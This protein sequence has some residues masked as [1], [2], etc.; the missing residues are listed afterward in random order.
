MAVEFAEEMDVEEGVRMAVESP[1]VENYV[2]GLNK[3]RECAAQ[4]S[5][6]L[7]AL[8]ES[9]DGGNVESLRAMSVYSDLNAVRLAVQHLDASVH[10][11]G[12]WID[13][14]K[15]CGNRRQMDL[16]FFGFLPDELILHIFQFL[17]PVSLCRCN[18]VSSTWRG[19]SNEECLWEK[20][21][22]EFWPDIREICTQIQN[23]WKWIFQSRYRRFLPGERRD[24]CGW[25]ALPNGNR[26]YGDWKNDLRDGWGVNVMSNGRIYEGEYVDDKRNGWGLFRWPGGHE[27]AGDTYIGEWKDSKRHGYGKYTWADGRVYDGK[28]QNDRRAGGCSSYPN[29]QIYMGEYVDG[30]RHGHGKTTYPTGEVFEGEYQN[31]KRSGHGE[32]IWTDGSRFVGKWV[33]GKRT[34]A[35]VLFMDGKKYSQNWSEQQFDL[36]DKGIDSQFCE[37]ELVVEEEEKSAHGIVLDADRME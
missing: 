18:M 29:G 9:N 12:V 22:M 21:T 6:S 31:N 2:Q 8:M 20:K 30:K 11:T 35:G 4:M 34:G 15:A 25:Y 28:W 24:G 1:R 32:L 27:H 23:P 10:A 3:I 33:R 17:D 36:G 16:G 5:A 26:F 14:L 37:C 13:F 19:L 7:L